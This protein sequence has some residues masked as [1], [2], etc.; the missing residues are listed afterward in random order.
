MTT[1]AFVDQ[2]YTVSSQANAYLSQN[3]YTVPSNKIAR[4]H[5][6][7]FFVTH[8]S[9]ASSST[10]F[11]EVSF[12]LYSDGSNVHRKHMYGYFDTSE[13]NIQM[14]SFY[15]PLEYRGSSYRAH[16]GSQSAM[17]EYSMFAQPENVVSSGTVD[18]TIS[19]SGT[20]HFDYTSTRTYGARVYGPGSFYM[21]EN[22]VLKCVG[23]ANTDTND[24]K[25]FNVRCAIF[26]EDE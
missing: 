18:T 25:Y 9:S 1:F 15:N 14:A 3:I 2:E 21:K 23:R 22:E 4:I 26:L 12:M 19:D 16:N 8:N 6:V 5:F 13:G 17:Y 10:C 7:G 20:G 24:N 11:K